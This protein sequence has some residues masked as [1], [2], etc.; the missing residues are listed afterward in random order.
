MADMR[1]EVQGS[2]L[3]TKELRLCLLQ[4]KRGKEGLG[5]NESL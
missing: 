4:E 5:E 3:A 1:G 2:E